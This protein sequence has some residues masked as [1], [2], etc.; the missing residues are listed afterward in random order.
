MKKFAITAFIFFI[1]LFSFSGCDKSTSPS[2]KERTTQL[3]TGKWK[4]ASADSWAMADGVNVS[5]LFNGFTLSFTE[6]GYTTTG[7]SPVWPASDTWNFKDD[8]FTLIVRGADGLEIRLITLDSNNLKMGFVWNQTTHK[9][10]RLHSIA[11][12]HEFTLTR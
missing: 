10:G 12:K 9:N 3:L 6:T 11:G 7:T 2:E 1:V 5:G 4:P 8:S